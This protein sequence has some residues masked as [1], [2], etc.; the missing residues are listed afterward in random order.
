MK[1]REKSSEQTEREERW[2]QNWG[3]R[4]E[5]AGG[6][7]QADTE[8]DLFQPQTN[9]SV[10]TTLTGTHV[11]HNTHTWDLPLAERRANFIQ[12]EVCGDPLINNNAPGFRHLHLLQLTGY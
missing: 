10:L 1:I 7:G 3:E 11:G 2:K 5:A 12:Q 6:R 9:Y 4:I 8:T